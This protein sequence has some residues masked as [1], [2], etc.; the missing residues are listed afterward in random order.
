MNIIHK[1]QRASYH[2]LEHGKTCGFDWCVIRLWL[3]QN[4]LLKDKYYCN[5]SS[6]TIVF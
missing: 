4:H 3:G 5:S 1:T 2:P 6:S